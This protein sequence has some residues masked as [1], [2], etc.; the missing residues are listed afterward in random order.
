MAWNQIKENTYCNSD[1]YNGIYDTSH[2]FLNCNT[3]Q[4][5]VTNTIITPNL[6]FFSK[7]LKINIPQNV[8]PWYQHHL[9]SERNRRGLIV[10][11][12][13]KMVGKPIYVISSVAHQYTFDYLST[14][15]AYN[16]NEIERINDVSCTCVNVPQR[17]SF[18][19]TFETYYKNLFHFSFHTPDPTKLRREKY[20]AAFHMNIDSL[21]TNGIIPYRPF[22]FDPTVK[23]PHPNKFLSWDDFT[24]TTNDYFTTT[25]NTDPTLDLNEIAMFL[26][27]QATP[28]PLVFKT[29]N[30]V[31]MNY[32]DDI[33]KPIYNKIVTD[34]LNPL[35]AITVPRI[36]PPAAINYGSTNHFVPCK[37]LRNIRNNTVKSNTLKNK[38]HTIL[39]G[40]KT[41][42]KR[43]RRTQR[44]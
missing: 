20:R 1:S 28:I 31:L 11:Y 18:L 34:V 4:P 38:G 29:R 5:W 27:K 7:M 41:R 26:H 10:K 16:I 32:V 24:G 8:A 14:T 25:N 44:K 21:K 33:V 15:K 37:D 30:G 42:K 43:H 35:A 3:I 17:G 12:K 19:Y 40:G 22:V 36:I 6:V 9:I 23:A 39:M 13:T 2:V